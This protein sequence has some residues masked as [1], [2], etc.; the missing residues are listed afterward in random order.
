MRSSE[1]FEILDSAEEVSALRPEVRE[2][3]Q[4]AYEELDSGEGDLPNG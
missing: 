4:R 3:L 1:L 2:Q